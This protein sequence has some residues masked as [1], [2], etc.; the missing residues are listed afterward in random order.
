MISLFLII[1]LVVIAIACFS[2]ITYFSIR[3]SSRFG[4]NFQIPNCPK[5]NQKLPPLRTPTSIQQSL[6]GGWTCFNC[7]CEIDKWGKE[8]TTF[9]NENY[10]K[11]I[12]Q[13]QTDFIKQFDEKGK[14]PIERVF[15][16]DK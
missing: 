8:I 5:C 7:G 10:Q 13:N 9:K 12:Q 16:N 11:Q 15:E 14:T 2:L 6:W 4:L 3:E 1:F